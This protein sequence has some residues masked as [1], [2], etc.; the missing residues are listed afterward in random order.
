MAAP[1]VS[2]IADGDGFAEMIYMLCECRT[3]IELGSQPTLDEVLNAIAEHNYE[4][5]LR[6]DNTGL[7]VR[8]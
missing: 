1:K 3:K 4:K 8:H 5:H 2:L 7:R 6:P